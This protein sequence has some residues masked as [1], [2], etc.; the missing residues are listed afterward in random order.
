MRSLL[1]S[2][3]LWKRG[4]R[5]VAHLLSALWSESWS[6][7]DKVL[8]F[9]CFA[10]HEVLRGSPPYLLCLQSA[11][12]QRLP[13]SFQEMIVQAGCGKGEMNEQPMMYEAVR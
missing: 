7:P 13:Y 10:A 11:C 12:I 9:L 8:C 2:G 3:S 4:Q 6:S 5:S 1:G